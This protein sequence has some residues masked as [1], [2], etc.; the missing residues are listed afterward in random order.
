MIRIADRDHEAKFAP[1][2]RAHSNLAVAPSAGR[3][4]RAIDV[5]CD[6]DEIDQKIWYVPD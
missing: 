5:S 2:G 6:F 3:L 1:P 4:V